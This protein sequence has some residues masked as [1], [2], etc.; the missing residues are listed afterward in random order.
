MDNSG[1]VRVRTMMSMSRR[2]L[3]KGAAALGV[4]AAT[5]STSQGRSGRRRRFDVRLAGL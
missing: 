2:D 4:I 3:M 5:R 1:L